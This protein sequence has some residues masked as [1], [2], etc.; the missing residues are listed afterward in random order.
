MNDNKE[1][2]L[3]V[4]ARDVFDVL[5]K[6]WLII[7]LCGL[8]VGSAFLLYTKTMVSKQYDSSTT[9]FVLSKQNDDRVSSTDIQIS[10]HLTNDYARIIKSRDV[11]EQVIERLD[12]QDM[13]PNAI[14]GKV[15][16]VTEEDTR[17]VT[18]VVRDT[19][20]AMAQKLADAIREVSAK[21]IVDVMKVEMVN[22]VDTASLPTSPSSP[23]TRNNMI[24]G[25]ALGFLLS[26]AI[27]LIK[28]Y[29]DDTIKD[30]EDVESYLNLNVL[31]TIP[32]NEPNVKKK[33][34]W[35]K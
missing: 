14:L 11:A 12:L 2:R 15:S 18:I 31:A 6:R 24:L 4:T 20:P 32:T 29:S 9:I 25:I 19:D 5:I 23:N 30:T 13:T 33:R 22:V 35:R 7:A 34:G 26:G 3:E 17:I 27:I 10:T 8:V 21:K 16:V 1:R 28:H